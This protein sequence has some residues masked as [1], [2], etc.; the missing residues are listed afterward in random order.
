MR[1]RNSPLATWSIVSEWDAL[2]IG[3]L[4]RV[5]GNSRAWMETVVLWRSFPLTED[6]P[7]MRTLKGPPPQDSRSITILMHRGGKMV[8]RSVDPSCEF[9]NL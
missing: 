2:S 1:D 8:D 6:V 3:T 9:E 7:Q 4:R 5:H